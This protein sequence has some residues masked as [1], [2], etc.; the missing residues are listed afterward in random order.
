MRRGFIAQRD[1][2]T[3]VEFA[4]IAPVF[5]AMIFGTIALGIAIWFTAVLNDVASESARC[6]AVHASTCNT[7]PAGCP[8]DAETCFVISLA[9]DRGLVGLSPGDVLIDRQSAAGAA[10]MTNVS[11]TFS[12]DLLGY[13]FT[14]HGR[15]AYPNS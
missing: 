2:A 9:D 12:F 10:V 6:I 15:A 14:L 11:L 1:G 13:A 4:L 7:P 5:F 3:A 8:S